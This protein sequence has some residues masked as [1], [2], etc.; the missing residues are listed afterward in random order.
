MAGAAARAGSAVTSHGG[1]DLEHIAALAFDTG[2]TVFDWHSAVQQA[3][4]RQGGIRHVEADWP[5]LTKTWRRLSTSMVDAGL[6]QEDGR[7]TIDMDDVLALTL[8]DTL[9]RHAVTG[10]TSDD[11]SELVHAW[12]RMEPWPDVATAMP[13]FRERFII[14]PFSI[15][16]TALLVE[17]SRRSQL[18]WDAVFSCEMMGVYKTHPTTYATVA[19]WLELP[20]DRI[21]MVSTHNNDI[22]AARASSFHTAFVYRPDEWSDIPSPDPEPG[23]AAELVASDF[24]DLARQLGLSLP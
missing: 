18:T 1:R 11:R 9:E 12:R 5:A 10:F 2:G 7:V 19:R 4:E 21:M 16:S 14:V 3:F 6:P 15:L 13:R 20:P 17:A 22:R 8:D 24:A 23:E